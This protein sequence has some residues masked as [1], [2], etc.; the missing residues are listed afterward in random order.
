MPAGKLSAQAGHA[1]TDVLDLATQNFPEIVS[2]YRNKENGGSK[3]TLKAKNA[4]HLIK[5]YEE[6]L[7]LGIPAQLIVDQGHVMPP[8]FNGDPII[9]AL[10]IGPCKQSDVKHITKKFQCV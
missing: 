10:G 2:R 5:A 1:Y 4:H 7:D 9:T 3:V 6:L 8:F